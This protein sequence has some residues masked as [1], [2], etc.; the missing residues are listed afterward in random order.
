MIKSVAEQTNLLALNAVI[1]AA[2]A[3]DQDRCFAV[4]AGEVRA[5]SQKIQASVFDI[6]N[7]IKKLQD[8]SE[9]IVI[10]LSNEEKQ[11]NNDNVKAEYGYMAELLMTAYINNNAVHQSLMN[12]FNT[13]E[14]DVISMMKTIK[15]NFFLTPKNRQIKKSN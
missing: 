15:S 8:V 2:R 12:C 5:L 6:E 3:G 7:M 1:E 10:L 11:F 9:K 13:S 4:V 14:S